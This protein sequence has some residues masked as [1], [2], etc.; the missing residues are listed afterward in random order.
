MEQALTLEAW[1][2][3]G[4]SMLGGSTVAVDIYFE[5]KAYE[6]SSLFC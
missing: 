2:F 4:A 5:K 1:S 3:Q 6:S